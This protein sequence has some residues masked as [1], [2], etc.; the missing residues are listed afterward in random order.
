MVVDHSWYTTHGSPKR[1]YN[2]KEDILLEEVYQC[3]LWLSMSHLKGQIT[4]NK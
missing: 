4:D 1:G 3:K 2:H